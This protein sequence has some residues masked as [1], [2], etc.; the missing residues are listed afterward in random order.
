MTMIPPTFSVII[1]A[2]K[3]LATLEKAVDSVCR[4]TYKGWELLIINDAS[5]DGTGALADQL[6][7]RDARIRVVHLPENRGKP[8]AMNVGTDAAQGTWIALL[9]ADDW[10]APERLEKLLSVAKDDVQMLA[11]NQFFFDGKANQIAGTAF[12]ATLP[13]AMLGLKEFLAAADA[14]ASFDYGMLKPVFRADFLRQHAIRYYEPAKVGED[15]LILLTF[16]VVGGRARLLP[17]PLYYYLQPFGTLSKQWAQDERKPYDFVLLEQINA[18]G[19]QTLHDKLKPA[20]RTLLA[21]RGHDI[22]ALARFD[23][24]RA[25]LNQRKILSA[26]NL[27]LTAPMP[28]WRLVENRI[29]QRLN[30]NWPPRPRVPQ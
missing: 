13:I 22:A 12:P 8:N 30:P 4:Q 28:F 18:H 3:A 9:D 23:R 19:L 1:P 24:L 14:M 26:L 11:D 5:P 29:L 27:I 7:T 10:Y 20:Q 17:E 6:A 25:A 16:F 2:Y 15:F 21:R